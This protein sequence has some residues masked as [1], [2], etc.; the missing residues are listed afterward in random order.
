MKYKV[1]VFVELNIEADDE[2]EAEMEALYW[3]KTA[4]CGDLEVDI[5][6]VE[7]D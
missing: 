1:K 6:E 3:I 4:S 5:E 7:N 2:Q